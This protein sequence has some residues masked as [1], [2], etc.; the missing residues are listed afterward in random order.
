MMTIRRHRSIILILL[1]PAVVGVLLFGGWAYG[2][3]R[4][5]FRKLKVLQTIMVLSR[6]VYV[7]E[8]DAN[9]LL[10]GAIEGL[11]DRLDPHSNYITP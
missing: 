11:L 4:Q 5:V 9:S 6:Q 7:D 2:Q 8:V 10:D 3:A 1:V